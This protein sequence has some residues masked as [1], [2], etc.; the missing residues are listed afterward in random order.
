M[1]SDDLGAIGELEVIDYLKALV[2]YIGC[3]RVAEPLLCATH[4]S[5]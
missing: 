4:C 1:G 5:A 2:R 3:R